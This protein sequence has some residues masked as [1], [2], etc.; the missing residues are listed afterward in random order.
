MGRSNVAVVLVVYRNW[1]DTASCIESIETMRLRPDLIVVVNNSPEIPI[2]ESLKRPGISHLPTPA[3][4]GFAGGCNAGANYALAAG[5]DFVWFLNTDTLVEEASL[6]SLL[7]VYRE[8]SDRFGACS[9]VTV[10][11]NDPAMVQWAGG[12]ILPLAAGVRVLSGV[13]LESLQGNRAERVSFVHG[14]S[15]LMHKDALVATKGFGEAYFMYFEDADLS[16]RLIELGFTLWNT[17][18]SV[19]RHAGGGS[20]GG[21]WSANGAYYYARNRVW[22]ARAH[23]VV[24]VSVVVTFVL[25]LA[26]SMRQRI[27]HR[28]AIPWSKV[29]DGLRDGLFTSPPTTGNE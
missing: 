7:E 23:G 5:A 25:H 2:P 27:V 4:L 11:M 19:V 12:R 10:L 15:L 26:W 16:A 22:F 21:I 9:S 13:P 8:R 20:G 3:N 6:E 28:R 14:C 17:R 29:V 24:G 18:K 1:H